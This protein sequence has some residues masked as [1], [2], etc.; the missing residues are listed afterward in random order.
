MI[1]TCP[2]RETKRLSKTKQSKTRRDETQVV[3]QKESTNSERKWKWKWKW[4]S[5]IEVAMTKRNRACFVR[6][7]LQSTN[8]TEQVIYGAER[9]GFVSKVTLSPRKNLIGG[10]QSTHTKKRHKQDATRTWM[11][12]ERKRAR[13]ARSGQGAHGI[14]ASLSPVRRTRCMDG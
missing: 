3:E 1:A 6:I 13:R 11:H 4:K 7:P 5:P 2:L 14:R 10:A 12:A 8:R 9:T